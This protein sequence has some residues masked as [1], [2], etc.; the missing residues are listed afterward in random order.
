[1]NQ[2]IKL[3]GEKAQGIK[4]GQL[5]RAELGSTE[6]RRFVLLTPVELCTKDTASMC[7][8]DLIVSTI[9]EINLKFPSDLVGSVREEPV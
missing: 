7:T 4:E 2:A 8:K 5:F 6:G 9:D 1:M 3:F